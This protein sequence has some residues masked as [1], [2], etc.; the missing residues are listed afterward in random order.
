MTDDNVDPSKLKEGHAH[1]QHAINQI[2]GFW[3]SAGST[4]LIP[5]PDMNRR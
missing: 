1:A 2:G 3:P 4:Q 5:D